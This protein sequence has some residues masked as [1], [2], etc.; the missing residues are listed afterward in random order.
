MLIDFDGDKSVTQTGNGA[1]RMSPV[2]S[3]VSVQ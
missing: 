2:I 3:I 1:Y